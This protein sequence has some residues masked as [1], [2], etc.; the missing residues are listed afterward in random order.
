MLVFDRSK[1]VILKIWMAAENPPVTL[2]PNDSM[3]IGLDT[4]DFL[5]HFFC[6]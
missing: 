6:Y 5:Y 1:P 2:S 3:V 4:Q